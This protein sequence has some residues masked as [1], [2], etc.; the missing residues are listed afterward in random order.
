MFTGKEWSGSI[1][2][3]RIVLSFHAVQEVVIGGMCCSRY[4]SSRLGRK[5]FG[6]GLKSDL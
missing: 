6:F 1:A 3:F 2:L 4:S 5:L